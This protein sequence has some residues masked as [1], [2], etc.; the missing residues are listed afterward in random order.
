MK[1]KTHLLLS[2]YTSLIF[3]LTL[4]CSLEQFVVRKA[5]GFFSDGLAVFMAESDLDLAEAAMPSNLKLLETMLSKDPENPEIL[6]FASQAYLGYTMAFVEDKGL[7]YEFN[8]D[9]LFNLYM[10]RAKK[11]YLR[12]RDFALKSVII[13]NDGKNPFKLRLNEYKKWLKNNTDKSW[14]PNLFW[15]AINWGGAI[16]VDREDLELFAKMA[17]IIATMERIN[18]LDENYFVGGGHLFLGMY[19][20]GLP[21][22]YGNNKDKALKHFNRLNQI[23]KNRHLL[24]KLFQ[25]QFLSVQYEDRP[26][27]D[28]LIKEILEAPDDLWPEQ[29]LINSLAKRKAVR[30]KAN[31]SEYF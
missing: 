28:R 12:G 23:S 5:A 8:N 29:G 21:A 1:R 27:F 9:K 31:V 26:M 7:D 6:Y 14:V 13:R 4:N 16:N 22:L 20:A 3:L 15:T 17:F 2:V 18:E 11:L 30:L 10:Q 24:G 25:A 19:Y